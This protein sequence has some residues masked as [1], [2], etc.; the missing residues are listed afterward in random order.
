MIESFNTFLLIMAIVAITVFIALY[1]VTAG[2][3]K[4]ATNKWGPAINNKIGWLIMEAPVRY[5]F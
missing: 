2:Y 4:F 5:L 3:G 1:F